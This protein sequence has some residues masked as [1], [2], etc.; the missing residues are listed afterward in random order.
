[1]KKPVLLFMMLLASGLLSAQDDYK[2]FMDSAGENSALFKGYTPMLYRFVHTG[3]YYAYEKSYLDGNV[4]YNGKKYR[5]VKLNLNSHLDELIVWDEKNNRNIQLNKSYVDTFTIGTRKFVNIRERDNSGLINPGYYQ[6][7]YD[8]KVSVYKKIAKV[9]SESINQEYIASNRGVIK[10]F[11]LSVKYILKNESGTYVIR[12]K[13]DI[14]DLYPD[15]KKEIRK[16]IRNNEIY[17]K[18]DSMDEA[19]VS[20]LTFIDNKQE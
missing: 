20:V 3:T 15:M 5:G 17:F 10:K 6:L 8:S 14:L 7:L 16:Y 12:R 19:I 18:E 9:Y 4:L 1:M 13:K 2:S 11:I